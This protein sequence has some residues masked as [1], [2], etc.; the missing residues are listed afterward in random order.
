[1]KVQYLLTIPQIRAISLLAHIDGKVLITV[2]E[3]GRRLVEYDI[4]TDQHCMLDSLL[5][6]KGYIIKNETQWPSDGDRY[7]YISAEGDVLFSNWRIS[8]NGAFSHIDS[9]RQDI[10]NVFK[11][12]EEAKFAYE[13]L[14]VF[15]KL[16][17]LSDD[18]QEWNG[19]N[20]H[21][22]I[23]YNMFYNSFDVW[24]RCCIKVPH[25]YWFKSEESAK[26]A[27][28]TIGEDKLKKYVFDI[29]E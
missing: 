8:K 29:K 22:H 14:K 21:Y 7:Y 16:K 15:N 13:K 26:A 4:T 25:E 17:S 19:D 2:D 18:D 1:M 3:D 27:I 24:A 6:Q 23:I 9:E 28:K 11:T 20:K 10:G 5:G 12:Q